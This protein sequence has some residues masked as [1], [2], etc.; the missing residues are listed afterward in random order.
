V[1]GGSGLN[2]G[3]A[4]ISSEVT[5][6]ASLPGGRSVT[7]F[8]LMEKVSDMGLRRAGRPDS[9]RFAAIMT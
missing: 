7:P 2:G 1:P 6:A 5:I 8:R 4:R 9:I 3:G